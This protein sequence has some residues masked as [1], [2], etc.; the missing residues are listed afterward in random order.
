MAELEIG[1]VIPDF[2]I[3]NQDGTAIKRDSLRGKWTILYFYP[4]D[5]TP[6]CSQEAVE[7]SS[8]KKEMEDLGVKIIGVSR[9]SIAS[10]KKFI[11]KKE[12]TIELLSSEESDMAEKFG[13]WQLKKNYGKEYMGIVRTTYIV[14]PELKVEAV[15]K[16]VK[17]KE[18]AKA[19]ISKV[20]ELIK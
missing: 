10:H 8:Y 4:K 9:D 2:E 7:F 18:H 15:W 16:K 1:A 14:S 19:V 3:N 11:E 12:L 13:V 6:G 20:K 17:V 5:N